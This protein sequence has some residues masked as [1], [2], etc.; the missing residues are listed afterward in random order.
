[1]INVYID[2]ACT[3]NG[4]QNAVAGYGVFFAEND[5]RNDN[6]LVDGKQ[7]NNTGELT[8]FI[9]AHEILKQ[10]IQNKKLIHIYTDSEYVMKCVTTYGDKLKQNN[11]KTSNG[12]S[13]P[14]VDLVKQAY[15]TYQDSKISVRLHHIAAHTNKTDEHSIGNAGADRLACLATGQMWKSS[16][17]SEDT[18][19]MSRVARIHLDWISFHNKDIAKEL[20]AKW[21]HK[22]KIWYVDADNKNMEKLQELQTASPSQKSTIKDERKHYINV[23]YAKRGEAKAKGARWDPSVKSW[24]YTDSIKDEQKEA[25]LKITAASKK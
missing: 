13:P 4:Q 3:N 14:N 16:E 7:T 9:K 15:E 23:S 20:G 21:D 10:D 25:L 1:M 17:N 6:G 19:S 8:A 2:G 18:D 11:W 24:Y 5:S 12:K 22:K